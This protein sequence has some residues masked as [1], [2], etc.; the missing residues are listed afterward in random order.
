MKVVV[1]G[2]QA[3]EDLRQ[4]IPF[5]VPQVGQAQHVPARKE[6]DLEGPDGPEG[7]YGHPMPVLHHQALVLFGV[8]GRIVEQ[9][10]PAMLHRVRLLLPLLFGGLVGQGATG[11]DLPMR[12]GIGAAHNCALVLEHLCP[13]VLLPQ[14]GHL[15]GPHIHHPAHILRRHLRQG[16]VVP[17]RKAHHPARAWLALVAEKRVGAAC[18]RRVWQ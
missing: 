4:G 9:K 13:A 10:G 5:V 12:V 15:L 11:P 14:L 7:H 1:P 16:G 17:G 3:F 6:Q 18:G 8:Q 2:E